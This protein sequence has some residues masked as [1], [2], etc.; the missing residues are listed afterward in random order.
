MDAIEKK[1]CRCCGFAIEN[2][3]PEESRA[4]SCNRTGKA[5]RTALHVV[6]M[7][8]CFRLAQQVIEV[9]K[10]RHSPFLINL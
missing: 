2:M 7:Q 4:A 8:G 9:H 6:A 5:G 10:P 3:W 1:D